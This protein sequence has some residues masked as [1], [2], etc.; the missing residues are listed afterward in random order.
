LNVA[1]GTYAGFGAKALVGGGNVYLL[2]AGV[3]STFIDQ[4]PNDGVYNKGETI[5]FYIPTGVYWYFD[6]CTLQNTVSGLNCISAYNAPNAIGIGP[7]NENGG[8]LN[9]I[10]NSP[11]NGVVQISAPGASFQ[12]FS[13]NIGVSGSGRV[14]LWAEENASMFLNGTY[15][16]TGTPTFTDGVFEADLAGQIQIA[17]ASF[18]GAVTAA[19]A[20]LRWGGIFNIIFFA[21]YT[22]PGSGAVV[23]DGS[24]IFSTLDVSTGLNL[25]G[26]VA[27][28]LTV[29]QLPPASL[30]M[31]G[32]F[33]VTDST[34]VAAGNFGA[35]VAGGSSGHGNVPVY[36]DG[37]NWRIG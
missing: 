12:D 4:G 13:S 31:R 17:F 9:I 27:A 30:M 21:S 7:P 35:I 33:L 34:V 6:G 23:S 22:L 16:F 28:A 25:G 29:S 36:P 8:N 5:S 37:T 15:T 20:L 10:G 24:G 18:S 11:N 2:G 32:N 14:F 26:P 1:A 19:S 3:G